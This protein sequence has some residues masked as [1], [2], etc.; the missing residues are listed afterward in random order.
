MRV[1]YQAVLALNTIL[2][3]NRNTKTHEKKNPN[4][5]F[6]EIIH[7]VPPVVLQTQ[8][9]KEKLA[10]C[11]KRTLNLAVELEMQKLVKNILKKLNYF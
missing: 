7:T 2:P 5:F 10:E 6:T 11:Y 3:K 4:P 1:L 8:E 9:D